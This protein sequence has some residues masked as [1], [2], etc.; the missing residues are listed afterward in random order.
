MSAALGQNLILKMKPRRARSLV[1]ADGPFDVDGLAKTGVGIAEQRQRG[2]RR[3][4]RG[5]LGELR[6]GQEANVGKSCPAR[7]ER[8]PRKINCGKPNPL[9]EFGR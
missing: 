4:P 1:G 5:L 8:A 7:R 9:S 2:C 3:Q 6:E